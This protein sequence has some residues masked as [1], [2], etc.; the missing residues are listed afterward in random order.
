M[1]SYHVTL[2]DKLLGN[3]RAIFFPLYRVYTSLRRLLDSTLAGS[4][5]RQGTLSFNP[6][7]LLGIVTEENPVTVAGGRMQ[8]VDMW[9]FKSHRSFFTSCGSGGKDGTVRGGI[10]SKSPRASKLTMSDATEQKQ[11]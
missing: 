4:D 7:L 2:I 5:R 6:Q 3:A 8:A 1:Y 9:A 11:H 10:I